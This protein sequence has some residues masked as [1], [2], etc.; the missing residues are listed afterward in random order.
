MPFLTDPFLPFSVSSLAALSLGQPVH[1]V[2]AVVGDELVVGPLLRFLV[3]GQ[4]GKR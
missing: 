3:P 1:L 4:A 2:I